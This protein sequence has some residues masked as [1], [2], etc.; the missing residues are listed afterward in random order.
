MAETTDLYNPIMSVDGVAVRSP[1][2]Y[3]WNLQ[4]VSSPDAGR[5]EDALMHKKRIAQK[6]K[7]Q[8]AWNNIRIEDASAILNAF[9]DEYVEVCYLDPK[10]GGYL[11]KT[12]YVGDRSSPMYNNT[13]N[14]WSNVAF[15]IIEQ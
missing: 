8:L 9:D 10:A 12:F 1:S 5:T 7:L 4:D 15:N 14:V 3:Q 11:T 2:V 6:V 13:C